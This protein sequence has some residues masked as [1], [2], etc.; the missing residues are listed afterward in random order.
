[1]CVAS[2]I[3]MRKKHNNRKKVFNNNAP[4]IM[5]KKV[6]MCISGVISEKQKEPMKKMTQ[7][8]SF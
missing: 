4:S 2:F 6:K 8:I 3:I 7:S 5:E 1:M